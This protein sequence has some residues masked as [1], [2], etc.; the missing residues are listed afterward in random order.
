ML[1]S[2]IRTV[3]CSGRL[4]ERGVYPGGMVSAPGESLPGGCVSAWEGECLPSAWGGV[5][6]PPL[7]RQT[8]VKT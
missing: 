8:P 4:L 6:T 3:R 2:R 5:Y 1:S 7:D